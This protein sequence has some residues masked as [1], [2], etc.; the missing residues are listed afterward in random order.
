M[1]ICINAEHS[2]N[3]NYTNMYTYT[4]YFIDAFH[5]LQVLHT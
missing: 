3:N 1:Y 2:E 5:Q 4:P